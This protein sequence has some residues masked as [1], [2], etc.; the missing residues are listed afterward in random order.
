[1]TATLEQPAT[2]E[3][4]RTKLQSRVAALKVEIAN[5]RAAKVRSE[6]ALDHRLRS[7]S[8]LESQIAMCGPGAA[9][10]PHE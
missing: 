2:A 3:L 9:P 10:S 1:M 8:R 7:L 6:I 5:L 4:D